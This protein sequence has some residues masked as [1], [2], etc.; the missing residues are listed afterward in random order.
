M[1]IIDQFRFEQLNSLGNSFPT[2]AAYGSNGAMPHYVPLEST[3]VMVGNDSTL[4]LDSGGQYL[5]GTTDVTRTIHFGTPTK[6][7]KEAYTRVL[8]GQIQLSMLTFPASL[9]TS[10]LDVMARAPLWEVGLDY[11]HG[12]GHGVGAF[13][14][15]H[16]P[17]ISLYFNNPQSAFPE[18]DVLKP[19]YFLSNGTNS[20]FFLHTSQVFFSRTWVLQRK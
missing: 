8:I 5:D 19:G 18:N 2:I 11:D 20:P 13:L 6:E 10:A 12:T 16:E 17:P 15:V 7:Q 4:V 9:Q 3:N 14:S 1:K